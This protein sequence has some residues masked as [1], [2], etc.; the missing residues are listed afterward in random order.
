MELWTNPTLR[1]LKAASQ[2]LDFRKGPTKK[3]KLPVP[4]SLIIF[5]FTK[6]ST[7]LKATVHFL[8]L[9]TSLCPLVISLLLSSRAG[10]H[11]HSH[12]ESIVLKTKETR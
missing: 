4:F 11:R 10:S 5:F 2:Q 7:S 12:R 8:F 6:I 3:F 1:L 9:S